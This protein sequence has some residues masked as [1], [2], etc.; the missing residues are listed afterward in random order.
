MPRF[1]TAGDL[2][3]RVAVSVGLERSP[4]PFYSVDPAFIQL[5]E[6]ANEFGESIIHA[7]P[8]EILEKEHSFTTQAGD[9]GDYPLPDDFNYMIDQTAWQKG[10]PGAAYP[11]L[12]PAS[13]QWWSYLQASQL[14]NVT[15]Y[16]WFRQNDYKLKLFPQ[17]PPVGIPISFRYISRNWVQDG[18]TVPPDVVLKDQVQVA[19][20]VVLIDP[21]LFIKGLKL[22]FLSAK[23][24]DTSKAQ[25]DFMLMLDM[26]TGHDQPA[27]KLNLVGGGITLWRPL[28]SIINVPQTGY[29]D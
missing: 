9:S 26:I 10:S 21:I 28:D 22:S 14:Y 13:A 3:N 8:W 19:S 20:D 23:G 25:D 2:I 18:Q 24:F 11:L 17:P 4:D 5:I 15:I 27:P 6:L 1:Q 29:G 16:A 12:G 7:Y